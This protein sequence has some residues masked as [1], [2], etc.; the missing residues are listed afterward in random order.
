VFYEEAIS[1]ELR[2]KASDAFTHSQTVVG[3][4]FD[5]EDPTPQNIRL[6]PI[7]S[8]ERHALTRAWN[9]AVNFVINTTKDKDRILLKDML[10]VAANFTG[11]SAAIID[12]YDNLL[13][14]MS[15]GPTAINTPLQNLVQ[16]YTRCRWEVKNARGQRNFSGYLPHPRRCKIVLYKGLG[17][18]PTDVFDLGVYGSTLQK[19]A[20]AAGGLYYFNATQ[21][22]ADLK[23]MVS[24]LPPLYCDSD[25]LALSATQ[26]Q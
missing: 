21:D 9:L 19:R 18:K 24:A 15:G 5:G 17:T 3:K 8:P 1:T 14:L 22:S 16:S 25:K 10:A 4:I 2:D 13:L 11:N 23:A 7:T 6:L 20:E 26:L 12:P